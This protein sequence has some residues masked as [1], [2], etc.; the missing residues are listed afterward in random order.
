MNAENITGYTVE[1]VHASSCLPASGNGFRQNPRKEKEAL[2]QAIFAF[3][4]GL[5]CL[6]Y[7]LSEVRGLR[8]APTRS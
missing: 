7:A 3:L 4:P 2:R 5:K 6:S 1:Y 8:C